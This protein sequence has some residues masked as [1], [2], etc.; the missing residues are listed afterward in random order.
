M[1]NA[2]LCPCG[3]CRNRVRHVL[4][5]LMGYSD[6][7]PITQPP[8]VE[9]IAEELVA[10]VELA[11]EDLMPKFEGEPQRYPILKMPPAQTIKIG[12]GYPKGGKS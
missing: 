6:L 5:G 3:P 9:G 11:V 10:A 1:K 4:Y 2:R 12:S 8:N 7:T